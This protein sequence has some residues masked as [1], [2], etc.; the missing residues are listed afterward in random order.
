MMDNEIIPHS[1]PSITDSDIKAVTETLKSGQLTQGPV[2]HKFEKNLAEFIGKKGGTATSSGSAALHLALLA[3]DV[4]EEDEVIIPS[5]VCTAVLNAINYTGA[6]P[7]ITDIEPLTFNISVDAVKKTLTSKTK[8]IIVPHMFGCPAEMDKL[9]ELGIP[10]IED[11]AQAV[12]ATFKGKNVGSLGLLS[13]FSFYATKV[14]ACGEGGMVLSDSEGLISKIKD[15]RDYDNKNDYIL[16][17]NYKMTDIQASLGLSQLSSLEK[18]IEK[19]RKI[20]GQY[21]EEFKN[22]NLTLPIRKEG[23]EHLYY[24]FVV[25]T[26]ED[27]S[28]Y[29]EKLQQKHV[30]CQR[31][32]YK[33][34]H[35]YVNLSG[36]PHAMEAWQKAIS[37]PLYPSLKERE[38]EKIVT[39]V[40]EI[41]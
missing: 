36:F 33:P 15:L 30:T 35:H 4:K 14:F 38:I 31:P 40:K 10:I 29:L 5:F 34:L 24:R 8:A 7:V 9:S 37:I 27:A 2:V 23:K 3:L 32:V 39:V 19:R 13:V 17:Y 41:F 20:A 28:G 11:C 25:K 18:L 26:E 21:F 6:N 22:C 12:G 1:R 16:R